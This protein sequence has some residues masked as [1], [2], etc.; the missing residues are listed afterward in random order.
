M[1]LLFLIIIIAHLCACGFVKIA[2]E[3]I[4]NDIKPNWINDGPTKA[5][6]E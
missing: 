5:P 4:K 2:M 3:E 6:L 1:N